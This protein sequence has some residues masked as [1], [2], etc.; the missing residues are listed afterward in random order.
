MYRNGNKYPG[1]IHFVHSNPYTNETAVLGIFMES[2]FVTNETENNSLHFYDE[3]TQEEWQRFFDIAQTLK[4]EDDVAVFNIN[5]SALMGKN[6]NDFWRYH[7]SL[8]TPPC[9]EN[10]F[11]TIFKQPILFMEN[12]L[13][14]FRKNIYFEDY[15]RPQPLYTRSIYRNFPNESLSSIPDYNCCPRKVP[16]QLSNKSVSSYA[17]TYSIFIIIFV[18]F[19]SLYYVVI[20]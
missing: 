10:V 2:L 5:L 14:S 6:L 15:R 3:D 9:T 17:S 7:G 1:E 8:T 13:E 11:W 12:E 16:N 19:F 20:F 4:E 18:C